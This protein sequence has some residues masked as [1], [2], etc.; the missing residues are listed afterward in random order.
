MTGVLVS[1][2]KYYR[3]STVPP[4]IPARQHRNTTGYLL[5]LPQYLHDN[6]EILQVIY[7][8]S[9]DTYTTIQKY[10]RLSTVPPMIPTRQYRNTTGYLLCLPRYLHDNTE[11]LQVIYCASHDTCAMIQRYYRLST[12]PPTIPAQQHRN[13]TGLSTVPPTIP[14]KHRNT[15]GLSTVPPMI[16]ARQHRNTTGYLHIA[17]YFLPECCVPLIIQYT[18]LPPNYIADYNYC[19]PPLISL[20]SYFS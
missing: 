6:T 9:H 14:E 18:G 1:I 5:C 19:M 2:Q 12:V 20:N 15:T 8:A 11:I 10:Y 7:C 17:A 4:T 13:T 3:L 16:P